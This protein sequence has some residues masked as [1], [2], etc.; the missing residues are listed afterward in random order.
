MNG[1]PGGRSPSGIPVDDILIASPLARRIT[2]STWPAPTNVIAP[3]GE[4]QLGERRRDV[5]LR[6]RGSIEQAA[7]GFRQFRERQGAAE[8]RAE[9]RLHV[10]HHQRGRQSLAGHVGDTE[11]EPRS[12]RPGEVSAS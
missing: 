5:L 9:R 7:R 6:R 11:Q 10:A 4:L 8:Q 3:G 1:K 2:L 12:V